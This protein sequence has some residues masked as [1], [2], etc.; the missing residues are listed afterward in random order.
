MLE[1]FLEVRSWDEITG[2]IR[3]ECLT[4]PYSALR[5]SIEHEYIDGVIEA[6]RQGARL[7]STDL[8]RLGQTD[9]KFLKAFMDLYR[10]EV[11]NHAY[12]DRPLDGML[13]VAILNNPD[14]A[15][16]LH[17][18]LGGRLNPVIINIL[19]YGFGGQLYRTQKATRVILSLGTCK[20]RELYS[21]YIARSIVTPR[22]MHLR[23]DDMNTHFGRLRVILNELFINKPIGCG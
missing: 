11:F 4:N 21:E 20:H 18:E 22:V 15:E 5:M 2:E 13:G 8:L 14:T 19:L 7:T 10:S 16:Y 12:V 1:D 17:T 23:G 9:V 3:D 6:F